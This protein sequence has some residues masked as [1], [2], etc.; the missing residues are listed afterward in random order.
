MSDL[1]QLI[2]N[3]K[4]VI[5]KKSYLSGKY[6][7]NK[8]ANKCLKDS[9]KSKRAGVHGSWNQRL[10]AAAANRAHASRVFDSTR[11]Y[12]GSVTEILA[13]TIFERQSINVRIVYRLL[14]IVPERSKR[15]DRIHNHLDYSFGESFIIWQPAV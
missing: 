5:I 6:T 8:N 3:M 7:L 2:E 14:S 13:A 12:I 11:I 15:S 9:E 10:E 1:K 4:T